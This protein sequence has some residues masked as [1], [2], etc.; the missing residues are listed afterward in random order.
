MNTLPLDVGAKERFLAGVANDLRNELVRAAPFKT[1]TLANSLKLQR[2]PDGSYAISAVYYSVYV[3]FGSSPHDISR[4]DK[5]GIKIHHPGT[6]PNPFIR[7]T[8]K[9]MLPGIISKN[10]KLHLVTSV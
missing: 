9:N 4:K 8:I 5:V 6:Q 10:V 2:Q 7:W 3:E 1:G